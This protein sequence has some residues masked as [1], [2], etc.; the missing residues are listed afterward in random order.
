[1]NNQNKQNQKEQDHSS[2]LHLGDS[3]LQSPEEH[4]Q[5]SK[6]SATE[7]DNLTAVNIDLNTTQADKMAGSDR[8]GTAERED[9]TI[10]GE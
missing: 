4:S 6:R 10:D 1:M 2:E 9:N 3:T 7:G 5:D 8:A